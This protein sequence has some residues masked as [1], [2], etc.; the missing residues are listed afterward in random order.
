MTNAQL[1]ADF[2]A[3]LAA[4]TAEFDRMDTAVERVSASVFLPVFVSG[5]V[6]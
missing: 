1:L 6:L 4:D 5:T 2:A 3:T